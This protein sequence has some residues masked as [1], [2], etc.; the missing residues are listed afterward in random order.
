MTRDQEEL[1][2]KAGESI[3]AAKILM[4]EGFGGFAASRAYYSMFYVAQSF[5]E[6]EGLSFSKHYS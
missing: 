6:G 2:L 1:L 3:E 5:L 4:R